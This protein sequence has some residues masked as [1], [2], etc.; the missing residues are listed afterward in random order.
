MTNDTRFEKMLRRVGKDFYRTYISEV[1]I[2]TTDGN[3]NSLIQKVKRERADIV[4]A[5][6]RINAMASAVRQRYDYDI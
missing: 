2:A 1:R 5:D 3:I 6:F 4:T